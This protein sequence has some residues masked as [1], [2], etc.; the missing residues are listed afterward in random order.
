M[1]L[2]RLVKGLAQG[3]ARSLFTLALACGLQDLNANASELTPV[4]PEQKHEMK[5]Q[6][7]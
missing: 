2:Y 5:S 6:P 4:L 3:V 7:L 1:L